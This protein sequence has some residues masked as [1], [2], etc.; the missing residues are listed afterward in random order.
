MKILLKISSQ[1][2]SLHIAALLT[3]EFQKTFY[4]SIED[5]LDQADEVDKKFLQVNFIRLLITWLKLF[6][7]DTID[8]L[9]CS[10]FIFLGFG[11][12]RRPFR[13]PRMLP[14]APSRSRVK[15]YT[16]WVPIESSKH[17]GPLFQNL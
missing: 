14:N 7:I 9:K 8:T 3:P 16:I 12:A 10:A 6:F 2:Y 11:F 13:I 1:A 15:V 4:D 5:I 17:F